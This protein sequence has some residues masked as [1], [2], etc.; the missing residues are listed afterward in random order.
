LLQQLV[1]WLMFFAL[2][3]ICIGI[4]N[5]HRSLLPLL[6][7][8]PVDGREKGARTNYLF[9][10]TL[11]SSLTKADCLPF[12]RSDNASALRVGRPNN[13]CKYPLLKG[14]WNSSCYRVEALKFL[15]CVRQYL[16]EREPRPFTCCLWWQNLSS[17]AW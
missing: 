10:S 5:G 9:L 8:C 15:V 17:L 6:G 1:L 4:F 11:S 14:V 16:G 12:D 7:C 13:S 3:L 2:T